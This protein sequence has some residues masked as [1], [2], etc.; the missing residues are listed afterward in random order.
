MVCLLNTYKDTN[1][2]SHSQHSNGFSPVWLCW[3]FVR[4]TFQAKLLPHSRHLWGFIPEWT[5]CS[6]LFL[7]HSRPNVT[8]HFEHLKR[9]WLM[10]GAWLPPIM[11][12]SLATCTD[13][14]RLKVYFLVK[15]LPHSWH[16]N[17]L[18]SVWVRS[19]RL[20]CP[21][22]LKI[23]PHSWQLW[24]LFLWSIFLPFF[25]PALL[26]LFLKIFPSSSPEMLTSAF[27]VS[28]IGSGT[29]SGF[30]CGNLPS[31]PTWPVSLW[32]EISLQRCFLCLARNDDPAKTS[33]QCSQ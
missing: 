22:C 7:S 29:F 21:P 8:S 6:C 14:W 16:L 11:W 20:K 12:P 1:F 31:S 26:S 27:L 10:I 5:R 19:C 17:G 13:L 32:L 18:L 28:G 15:L 33:W 2:F 4:Q 3:C 23:F 24:D 9:S 30:W 25:F